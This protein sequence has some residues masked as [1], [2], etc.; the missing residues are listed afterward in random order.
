[1]DIRCRLA[2]AADPTRSQRR[3]TEMMVSST[4]TV[5]QTY[6]YAQLQYEQTTR[7]A[8]PVDAQAEPAPVEEPVGEDE[9]GDAL[10]GEGMLEKLMAGGFHGVAAARLR[11]NFQA[12]VTTIQQEQM[13]SDALAV[14]DK[15][16]EAVDDLL[17]AM[18]D[19]TELIEEQITALEE[20]Q[21]AF[22]GA[23]ASARDAFAASQPPD[24]QGMSVRAQIAGGTLVQSLSV[25]PA[26][27]PPSQ[28]EE[29]AE[30]TDATE[31]ADAGSAEA[32]DGT[33]AGAAEE[34]EG[35][36]F[37]DLLAQVQEVVAGF[38]ERLES[39]VELTPLPELP[40]PDGNGVAYS[41]FVSVYQES[42]AFQLTATSGVEGDEAFEPVDADA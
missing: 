5:T 39:A 26:I 24:G 38:L 30:P 12:E 41:R 32:V 14:V 17:E 40:E 6:F 27:E 20:A 31:T 18:G 25:I 16:R 4:T 42:Y 35:P 2:R 11:I 29:T 22:D 33:D 23:I 34:P 15:F 10:R 37:E 36:T 13:R 8:L 9:G 3:E 19:L 7:Q 1:M 21:S 28:G